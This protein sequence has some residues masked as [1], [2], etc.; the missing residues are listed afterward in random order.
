MLRQTMCPHD[1][2]KIV[3]FI[4]FELIFVRTE[5]LLLRKSRVRTSIFSNMSTKCHNDEVEKWI[6]L[7]TILRVF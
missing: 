6:I 3:E 7:M 5:P 1:V 2:L 4:H